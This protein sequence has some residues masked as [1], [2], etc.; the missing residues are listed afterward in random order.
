MKIY[1]NSLARPKRAAKALVALVPHLQLSNAQ[2]AVAY[3]CDYESWDDLLRTAESPD[4]VPSVDDEDLSSSEFEARRSYQAT[5][6]R[7]FFSNTSKQA[8]EMVDAIAPSAR[9][10]SGEASR[11]VTGHAVYMPPSNLRFGP[12]YPMLYMLLYDVASIEI[13][14]VQPDDVYLMNT[15]LVSSLRL[16]FAGGANELGVDGVYLWKFLDMVPPPFADEAGDCVRNPFTKEPAEQLLWRVRT[17]HDCLFTQ[18]PPNERV[19]DPPLKIRLDMM[20][21]MVT[22]TYAP[23]LA[24]G[25]RKRLLDCLTT[26]DSADSPQIIGLQRDL[27]DLMR[28]YLH[29]GYMTLERK[30][31]AGNRIGQE[32]V[33]RAWTGDEDLRFDEFLMRFS[34]KQRSE[35]GAGGNLS[36]SE[37][38]RTEL[39]AKAPIVSV[40][41]G[42]F[43]EVK[44]NNPDLYRQVCD[45]LGL[46]SRTAAKTLVTLLL[47]TK[48]AELLRYCVVSPV[49]EAQRGKVLA[50]WVSTLPASKP[51]PRP[52]RG[53]YGPD[54]KEGDQRA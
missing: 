11:P 48:E 52:R 44:R 23:G 33:P 18:A 40:L 53:A 37:L 46:G 30:V 20:R 10:R 38:L 28:G 32:Y 47:T 16:T 21:G 41:A 51:R 22:A 17:A 3:I 31:V 35:S 13:D 6:A 36:F 43:A 26:L 7:K 45:E 4:T 50:A 34:P 1:F 8:R 14:F 5:R 19:G 2:Q 54:K 29:G 49:L 15:H 27:D 42:W 9:Q 12:D 39:E 25:T 24:A